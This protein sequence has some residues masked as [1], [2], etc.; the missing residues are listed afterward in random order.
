MEKAILIIANALI[1][2]A[3]LLAC[4]IALQDTGS[5]QEIQVILGGGAVVSM[6]VIAVS[7]K[8]EKRHEAKS[9]EVSTL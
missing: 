5:F 9:A 6:F 7:G 3:V 8:Q 2:G 4:A 1:W